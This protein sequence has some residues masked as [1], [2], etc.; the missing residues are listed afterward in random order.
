MKLLK[1]EGGVCEERVDLFG[2]QF[3]PATRVG[4][5]SN[6]ARLASLCLTTSDVC[7]KYLYCILY[8]VLYIN[9]LKWP[10]YKP[11]GPLDINILLSRKR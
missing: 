6:D 2:I 3:N 7:A 9:F 4:A 5:L 8:I 10:K 11:Q 1:V